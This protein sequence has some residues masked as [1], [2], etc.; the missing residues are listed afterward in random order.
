MGA[1][2]DVDLALGGALQDVP[3]VGGAAKA[4]DHLHLD[5][6]A[7]EA[8][9]EGLPVL[10]GQ[11][12]GGNQHR[13]LL[14]VQSRL[15]GGADRH[16]G[17]AVADVAADQ[18]VEGTRSLH[19]GQHVADRRELVGRLLV[20]KGGLEFAEHA[21]GGGIGET[22]VHLP[23]GKD[24]EQLPRQFFDRRP[25]LDLG[26]VPGTAPHLVE[27]RGV[28]FAADVLLHLFD[29]VDRDVKLVLA[30]VLQVQEIPF[31][32]P[33]LQMQQAQVAADAVV[34]VDH[35]VP[36]LELRQRGEQG[37][38]SG[39]GQPAPPDPPAEDLLLG[40]HRQLFV[41]EPE[42]GRQLA[43]QQSQL[44]GPHQLR[45]ARSLEGRAHAVGLE[46][47]DQALGL[48]ALVADQDHLPVLPLP[49]PQTL[50]ELVDAAAGLPEFGADI[51]VALGVEAVNR[52]FLLQA[53][54]PQAGE[55]DAAA[56]PDLPLQ[57]VRL[58]V[59]LGGGHVGVGAAAGAHF[60]LGHLGP[61][62]IGLGFHR[63]RVDDHPAPLGGI[64][65]QGV[66]PA[67]VERQQEGPAGAQQPLAGLLENRLAAGPG[68][69]QGV[70]ALL[71]AGGEGIQVFA[72]QHHLP[73]RQQHQLLELLVT[74]ALAGR[75]E[76]PHALD[77][78]AEELDPYRLAAGR[79]V[80][81][82]DIPAGGKGAAV[83]DQ[84]DRGVAEGH[85][86]AEQGLPV[87]LLL[88]D[89]PLAQSAQHLPGNHPLQRR[90]HRQHHG[91]GPA[92]V[93]GGQGSQPRGFHL[94]MGA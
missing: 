11:N 42:P 88:D 25:G 67:V 46:Q 93:Q 31:H 82:E 55:I 85:Q 72:G 83:L 94:G 21:V 64:V 71:E 2:E 65:E 9:A 5:R 56:K 37:L 89:Q 1:D 14:A 48:A 54:E 43:E 62:Q 7:P 17:L 76:R 45:R 63:R 91:P 35:E 12:C 3:D 81:V 26:L 47:I 44:A 4:R 75:V 10:A 33:H 24:L 50:G 18:P 60:A 51:A 40:D 32:R 8:P 30:G 90:P 28:P 59:Q 16:L 69:L 36:F 15:E 29:A 74:G 34:G 77:I 23:A 80:D 53:V 61:E 84:R 39:F 86:P 20:G 57:L 92:F 38:G 68:N 27:A 73:G 6:R 22:F 66:Q 70:A 13:H 41:V 87:V 49:A 79:R 52:S 58:E 19:V 78:V